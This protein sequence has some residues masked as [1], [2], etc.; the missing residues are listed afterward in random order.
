M[1]H[2]VHVEVVYAGPHGDTDFGG[3]QRNPVELGIRKSLAR[4]GHEQPHTA[5]APRR[6]DEVRAG[7]PW[8]VFYFGNHF[9]AVLRR[10]PKTERRNAVIAGTTQDPTRKLHARRVGIVRVVVRDDPEVEHARAAL[11]ERARCKLAF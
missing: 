11:A 1:L 7:V 5:A 6:W 3:R 10:I 2:E 4:H 9:G 8:Y